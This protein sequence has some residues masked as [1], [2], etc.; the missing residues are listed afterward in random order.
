[1]RIEITDS[2]R[3]EDEAFVVAQTREFNRQFT[4]KDVRRLC[5]FARD[6]GEA[7]VGGLTGMTYWG[8]LDVGYL[9]VET[10]RRNQGIASRLLA[11]AEAEA[12]RR[13]CRRVLLDTYSF[14]APEFYRK[15]GFREFGRLE[16]FN[17]GHVRHFLCKDIG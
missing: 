7:I 6:E 1:M 4:D 5:V 14:Q 10:S 16:G 13:G 2:P 3:E 15:L 8:Y 12:V 11:A 9:W 17:G